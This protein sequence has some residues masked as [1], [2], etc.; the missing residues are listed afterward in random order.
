[1]GGG[2]GLFKYL[3][4]ETF[5]ESEELKHRDPRQEKKCCHIHLE[6]KNVVIF[7]SSLRDSIVSKINISV[8]FFHKIII[9]LSSSFVTTV[10]WY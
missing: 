9:I 4:R 7:T 3:R 1:M 6:K 10:F 2:A 5:H 8:G